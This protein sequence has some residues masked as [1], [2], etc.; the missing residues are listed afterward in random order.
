MEF[1]DRIKF[2]K[3]EDYRVHQFVLNY[4]KWINLIEIIA[5]WSIMDNKFRNE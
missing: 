2:R 5:Y 3:M 4:T 1:S